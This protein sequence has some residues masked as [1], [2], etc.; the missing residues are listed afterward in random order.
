MELQLFFLSW[1]FFTVLFA[2]ILAK[3]QIKAAGVLGVLLGLLSSFAALFVCMPLINKIEKSS[4]NSEVQNN[5]AKY[6]LSKPAS[7][8]DAK[9]M[10]VGA[11][12]YTQPIDPSNQYFWEWEKWVVRS[13]GTMEVYS[14][15]PRAD[16][17]GEPKIERY[18]I[19]TEKYADTGERF[20]YLSVDGSFL[21]AIIHNPEQMVMSIGSN[22]EVPLLKGDNFP[23]SK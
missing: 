22:G 2:V 11:W 14:A 20:Y 4:S 21:G 5:P 12:T 9:A 18:T 1:V 6:H 3:K 23:F 10:V 19:R 17:W 8:E 7:I 13:D 15:P 16:N